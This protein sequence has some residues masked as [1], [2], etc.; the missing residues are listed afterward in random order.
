MISRPLEEYALIGDLR[1]A[2]L[3]DRGGSIAWLCWPRFDSP[4]CFASLLGSDGN[5]FWRVAPAAEVRAVERAYR[6]DSLVLETTYVCETGRVRVIDAMLPG[7]EAPRVVRSIVGEAGSVPMRMEMRIRFDY[8]QTVPWVHRR[9]GA[10]VA[11]SGPDGLVL[12]SDVEVRGESLSTVAD[13]TVEAGAHVAFDLASFRSYR[14]T[15]GPVNVR[16]A[17]QRADAFWRQWAGGCSYEGPHRDA[18]VR[19]LLT[20]KALTFNATGA[21]VAAPTTSLPERLG[22]VRNWD[23]RYCWLRDATFVLVAFLNAGYD[24]EAHAWRSWLLRAVAGAPANLQILYGIGGERRIIEYEADWLDGY[25]GSKPV[26]IGNAASEQLQLDVYGEV[27]DVMYQAH[28]AG[29]RPDEDEW[30]LSRAVVD[31]VEQRWCEPDRGIWE[32]RGEPRHFVHSKVLAWVAIDRAIRAAEEGG[33]DGPVERWRALREQIHAQVCEQGFDGKRNAFMQSYG[34]SI[35]DASALLIPLV[36]F[37]PPNDLRVRGTLAAIEQTLLRDG[38]VQRYEQPDAGV[39][40]LPPG[41]GAFL[42]CTFWLVDNYV[43]AGRDDEAR[44]LFERLLTI[45][46]DV[47]LLAEEYDPRDRRLLGNFPQAFSHVGLVNSAFNLSKGVGPALQR[48][49][50]A[51]RA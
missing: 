34:A 18:V 42:A 51:D 23:Y 22:G 8:G 37:L 47:G 26:R 21:V 24:A 5:G 41:E 27:I 44:E 33:L 6:T 10:Q 38:F 11:I 43:L 1:S 45:R 15:P 48:A 25:A 49:D 20:L 28:R 12:H 9:G 7:S 19:S 4:A 16:D 14:E 13:F 32:V 29:L 36:G 35:V 40:G 2:A 39:D 3:V 46:N 17:L 31:A 30:A 50:A